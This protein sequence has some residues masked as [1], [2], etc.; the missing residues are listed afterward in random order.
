MHLVLDLQACQSE[1]RVRGIGRFSLS[2]AKAMAAQPRGNE[3]TILMNGSMGDAIEDLRSQFVDLLPQSQLRTWE[4]IGPTA[5]LHPENRFR[6]H[7][8][9]VLRLHAL[10]ELKPDLVHVASLFD[11]WADDAIATV[12]QGSDCPVAVTLYDLIPLAMKERYLSPFPVFRNWYMAK[13]ASLRNSRVLLGISKY[14]CREASELL[15]IPEDRVV[16]ISGAADEMFQRLDDAEAFRGE[17]MSR[18]GLR[19]PYIMYTGGFDPRKN[20]A[21]LIRAFALL[22]EHVR[23]AYQLLIV[24]KAPPLEHQALLLQM[25]TAGIQEGEI[26]FTGYVADP[27][28]I[29]LYNLCDLYVFPSLQEG[30]GLPALEAMSCGA[31]VIGSDISSLPEVIGRADALFDP[32]DEQSIAGKMVQALTDCAFRNSLREH[33]LRQPAKFTWQES[34]RRALDAFEAVQGC[35]GSTTARSKRLREMG[36]ERTAF[37]PAPLSTVTTARFG[38]VRVYADPDCGGLQVTPDHSLDGFQRER[39]R[40]ER[41]VVEIADD[42]YCA[43]TLALA[44]EGEADLLVSDHNIGGALSALANESS[45]R[46]LVLELLYR[47]NGYSAVRSAIDANFSAEVLSRLVSLRGLAGLEGCQVLS[48]EADDRPGLSAVAWRT[49]VREVIAELR[50]LE[51]VKEASERDWEG[52]ADAIA[53]NVLQP[54]GTKQWFVDITNLCVRD[55]GTGIQRVVRQV[56]DQLMASPPPGY[57]VEPVYLDDD[58]VFRYARAYCTDRYFPG[59][60]LPPDEPV[61]FR[62]A[63]VLLGLDLVAHK[64]PGCVK[65]LRELR[66]R[67]VRQYF[68]VYD[69]LPILRPDCFDPPMVEVF[70]SWSVVIAEFADGLICISRSVADELERWLHQIRP[71]RK[72]PLGIGYFHL[73]ADLDSKAI[74]AAEGHD[75]LLDGL[76]KRPTFL[77]VGTIEPR[78][79]HAQALSAFEQLWN[80]DAQ[81]NLLIIGRPGWLSETLVQRLR[82]HPERGSRLHWIEN[83]NDALLLSAY[84][85]ASALLMAS[86]GEGFGLPLIEAAHHHLPLI[87]RDLPVFREIAGQHAFYFSGLEPEGL[88]RSIEE[89]LHLYIEGRAPRSDEIQRLTW[90]ESAAQ[91]VD[92]VC[93]EGW[94]HTWRADPVLR[95]SAYDHRLLSQVGRLTRGV[96]QTTGR[97][98]WLLY[99]PYLPL[100][101]G[102]YRVRLLGGWHLARGHAWAGFSVGTMA[103]PVIRKSLFPVVSNVPT[104]LVEL[105]VTLPTD[106]SDYQVRVF[107]N[108]EASLWIDEVV[109]EPSVNGHNASPPRDR[110]NSSAANAG[111]AGG[112]LAFKEKLSTGTD[113]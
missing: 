72:R 54:G 88:A 106:V 75:A 42:P 84:H 80:R 11:G 103:T 74:S 29:K 73:G 4:S 104:M 40:F 78:K 70:R 57:R 105:D 109:I 19:K 94:V 8:S 37:L 102:H 50:V 10:R 22:P 111:S 53:S 61:E 32:R 67:G 64:I 97:S 13:V 1:S 110:P 113:A 26:I 82:E 69:L 18:Y 3:I 83:A 55:A 39:H 86:E 31:A 58:R 30:F 71:E 25:A 43:K 46:P 28:L 49:R 107:V 96:L 65:L 2:L 66:N 5:Y 92:V 77:M 76:D 14:T 36:V 17:V 62:N 63:D 101:A 44:V 35:S 91:L 93:N 45:T 12:P 47:S 24:G 34:A 41:V 85:R 21:A 51:G 79:G 112:I 87:V 81:V 68:V 52:I 98:G 9:E 100:R 108:G 27:D 89:W 23:A 59:A 99:G 16:N 38:R 6:Q 95:H 33:A 7:A 15:G 56:L 60:T 90:R 48:R 20:I